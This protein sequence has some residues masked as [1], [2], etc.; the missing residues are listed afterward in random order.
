VSESEVLSDLRYEVDRVAELLSTVQA[1]RDGYKAERDRL[2]AVVDAVRGYLAAQAAWTA[3]KAEDAAT[4]W[5]LYD[6]MM[7]AWERL[8]E[9]VDQLDVSPITGGNDG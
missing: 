7:A 3:T 8:R 5:A 4:Q 2:R 9:L 1:D 6:P